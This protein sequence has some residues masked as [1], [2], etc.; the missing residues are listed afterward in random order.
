MADYAITNVARRIVYTGSAGVG[1]YSFTFPVLVNTDIA[2]YKNTTLLTL[3][4]DYTVT[5][6]GTTG[7]GSVTLVVAATGAD[8]ITIVGARSIER[9]TDFVTGGDFFANTLNTEL[10][11]ETI[12]IQQI[13]ETAERALR[14]PVTDPTSINMTLPLNTVRAN[15]TLAFDADG[16][17]V[18]GEQIGDYR[19]NWAAATSYNKRDLVKDTTTNNIYICLTAHTSSGSQPITTNTD[20]AKWGLIVDASASTNAASNSSNAAN[21]SS[22]FA[23]N[24]S[25]SANAASNSSNNASNFANNAS[26]SA[27]TASNAQANVAANASAASNSANNASNFA[28]NSSNSANASSNHANNASNFAN[29]ASNSATSSSGFAN[30]AS[31]FANNA[32]NSANAAAASSTTAN[33]AANNASNASSNSSNFANNSSNSANAAATSAS[34]ASNSANNASNSA[35]A[36]SSAQTAAEAARDATLSAYDNFDD[37][38]LGAKTSA[39]TLDNDGNALVGGAL[40]FDTV[41]QGMYVYTGTAWTAAYISGTGYLAAANNLSEL[42]NTTTARTNLGLAIGTNVQAYDADLSAIAA[43]APT[44]DNFIVGNGTA[45]VLETPAQSRTSLGLGTVATEDTVPVAK[46]GTGLTTLTANNVILGNGTSAPSF[47]APGTAGNVLSS[48][49]TTWASTAPASGARSGNTNVTLTSGAPNVTLTSSSNQLQTITATANGCSITLP[50]MTTL[51]AGSHYFVFYNTSA[52]AIAMK[53]TSGTVREYLAA[54]TVGF[55][56]VQDISSANGAWRILDPISA[57]SV[58]ASDYS[59]STITY[60]GTA[61]AIYKVGDNKFI[62]VSYVGNNGYVSLMTLDSSARTITVGGEINLSTV[63]TNLDSISF[64]SNGVDKGVLL[65]KGRTNS[66]SSTYTTRVFGLAIVSGSMYLSTAQTIS[67]TNGASNAGQ[68]TAR[69]SWCFADDVF[70]VHMG[71]QVS[72][73]GGWTAN[74]NGYVYKV[75]VSGTTVTLTAGTGNAVSFSGTGATTNYLEVWRT[76]KSNFAVDLYSSSGR[77]F[78]NVNTSTNTIT[79]G[80]R[81]SQTALYSTFF[82]SE[83]STSNDSLTYIFNGATPTKFINAS[84]NSVSVANGG[85][86]TVTVTGSSTYTFKSAPAASYSTGSAS[87]KV[88]S[89]YPTSASSYIVWD[90]T[91]K[92]LNV[93]DPSDAN[94]NFN[95]AGFNMAGFSYAY[96]TTSTSLALMGVSGSTLSYTFITPAS[97]FIG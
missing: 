39:P 8:R 85:T 43:L 20:S 74:Y 51:T 42:T 97:P 75:T 26:N 50:N 78:V 59:T 64:D 30:N 93:C 32:S 36:A 92:Q 81:T 47:V 21:N 4:T 88:T 77:H 1:P 71:L 89:V 56:N 53:D 91:N 2:V 24:A 6:S 54:N 45:W 94:F 10:D 16:N 7:Q 17:P 55:L 31:N 82:G 44:A 11:S 14:A 3:T 46:G 37:R 40:Y 29:N 95:Q 67:L 79:G 15:K 19:G 63:D 12:F 33:T 58:V 35:N 68:P 5:I 76:G 57:G 96:F 80:T 23:N 38:Y 73:N 60:T 25:N 66:A 70:V 84:G 62:L 48:N 49:G 41:A 69:V 90:N 28:N 34:G 61:G 83:V 13:A 86:A 9:S 22:N 18:V 87:V 65:I 72:G 27:N 52:F